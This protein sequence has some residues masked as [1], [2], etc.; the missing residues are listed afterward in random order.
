MRAHRSAVTLLPWRLPGGAG[1]TIR[2][3]IPLHHTTRRAA[4]WTARNGVAT[5]M[6]S[7][8]LISMLTDA[9]QRTLELV[10][11]LKPEQMS[12]PRLDIV[13]PLVWE[14]GHVA[15]FQ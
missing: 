5:L 9:R 10:S 15:W 7:K 4:R 1:H 6:R 12:V 2:M 14:M 8:D 3:R 13:N 11:D